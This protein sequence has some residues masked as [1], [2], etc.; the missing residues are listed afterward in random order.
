MSER[1][2]GAEREHVERMFEDFKVAA[3]AYTVEDIKSGG[4]FVRLLHVALDSYAKKV[5]AEYFRKKYP[6]LPPDLVVERQIALAKRYAMI[7]GGLSAGAYSGLVA[8]TIGSGGGASPATLPAAAVSFVADLTFTTTLQL[9]LAYDMAVLYGVPLDLEDPTD[10]Y[11]LIQVALGVKAA[12]TVQG[13]VGRLTPEAVRVLIKKTVSGPTLK[14]LQ[15]LPVIGKYLLQRNIIKFAIPL[16]NVPLS[17]GMNYLWTR[18]VA[19]RARQIFRTRAVIN[20]RATKIADELDEHPSLLVRTLWFIVQADQKQADGEADLLR[21]VGKIFADKPDAARIVEELEATVSLDRSALFAEIKA[22]PLEKRT[23]LLRAAI[24]GAAVDG[25]VHA[26]E[27]DAL[28]TFSRECEVPF[29]PDDVKT[30]VAD[31]F[32]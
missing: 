6:G 24:I 17:A 1:E 14:L 28:H 2:N 19:S 27:L 9:R 18:S 31:L 3:Q 12:Q 22:L 26:K 4:W 30:A 32:E 23:Q 29:D 16:V 11:D 13:A 10:L 15:A 8:A 5:D 25:E 7:E 20:E 21:Q